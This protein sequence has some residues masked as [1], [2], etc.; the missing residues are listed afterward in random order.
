VHVTNQPIVFHYEVGSEQELNN[1]N[2]VKVV[3]VAQYTYKVIRLHLQREKSVGLYRFYVFFSE[4]QALFIITNRQ[5]LR[6]EITVV[7]I[8]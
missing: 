5:W 8:P 2:I 4:F 3:I 1:D 7:V 6:R